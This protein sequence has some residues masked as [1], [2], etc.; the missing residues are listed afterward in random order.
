[1]RRPIPVSPGKLVPEPSTHICFSPNKLVA[2]SIIMAIDTIFLSVVY[3][4]VAAS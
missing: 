3:P 1:M 2:M 4:L